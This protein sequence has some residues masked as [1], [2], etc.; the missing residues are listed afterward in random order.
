MMD[1]NNTFP[2]S[3]ID[4]SIVFEVRIQPKSAKNEIKGLI[5]HALKVK[6]TSPPIEGRAN[7]ACIDLIAKEFSVRRS[8]VEIIRGHK[9]RTKTVRIV[10]I[11]PDEIQRIIDNKETSG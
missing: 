11:A 10:G 4:N 9:S 7:K 3:K 6:V 2:I 8:H 5:G 1:R